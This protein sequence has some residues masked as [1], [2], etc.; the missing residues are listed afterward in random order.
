[1]SFGIVATVLAIILILLVVGY[2]FVL[3]IWQRKGLTGPALR[4]R[5]AR[6]RKASAVVV[7][8]ILVIVVICWRALAEGWI[9]PG[10]GSA[11]AP[12]AAIVCLIGVV[13]VR[14]LWYFT[15][16]GGKL[17]WLNIVAYRVPLQAAI[18]AIVSI[19]T[20]WDFVGL[21]STAFSP[22]S[23]RLAINLLLVFVFLVVMVGIG[24]FFLQQILPNPEDMRDLITTIDER[25]KTAVDALKGASQLVSELENTLEERT[26]RLDKLRQEVEEY[27]ALAA[28]EEDKAK[29]IIQRLELAIN[30]GKGQERWVSLAINLVAGLILFGLGYWLRYL[31]ERLS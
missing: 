22:E 31:L 21:G 12:L 18:I 20:L 23:N 17:P 5:Q 2:G 30:K 26:L 9:P 11:L 28:V 8:I 19:F 7:F 24:E 13:E 3:H 6:I 10:P 27:S 14:G 25:T 16:P 1:M 4:L 15:R 29:V